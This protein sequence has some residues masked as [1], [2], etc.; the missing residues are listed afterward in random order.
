MQDLE[1]MKNAILHSKAA[2]SYLSTSTV[3]FYPYYSFDMNAPFVK[4]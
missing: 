4:K 2:M 1:D 3:F